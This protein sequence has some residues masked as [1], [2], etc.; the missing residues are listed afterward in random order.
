MMAI[1]MKGETIDLVTCPNQ[2][3][4]FEEWA[5]WFNNKEVV[6][7]IHQGTY[8]HTADGQRRFYGDMGEDRLAL[9]IQPK[10][11]QMPTGICSISN[12]NLNQR[13]GEF[14]IILGEKKLTSDSMFYGLEAKC[15]ITEYIFD[16]LPIERI[17]ST[18]STRLIKWQKYQPILG[19]FCEGFKFGSF[20]KRNI[21]IDEICTYTTRDICTKLKDM[22]GNSLWPGKKEFIRLM[23]TLK[24][25]D[26]EKRKMQI[27]NDNN[28]ILEAL[29]NA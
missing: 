16:E 8:P 3:E 29:V 28:M 17:S 4:F 18:Q 2:E 25:Y 20:W 13:S 12:I 27:E 26:I 6:D 21:Q 9:F 1:V 14:A 5:S 22:R 11:S 15:M 24:D 7:N 10:N 23:K 19:Y